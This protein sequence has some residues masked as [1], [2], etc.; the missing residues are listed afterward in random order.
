MAR[1]AA[2]SHRGVQSV[3]TRKVDQIVAGVCRYAPYAAIA[4]LPLFALLL[5]IAFLGGKRRHPT[6]PRRYAAHL[7]FGALIVVAVAWA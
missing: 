3:T 4:L 5:N 2:R 7:V 6:R 1:A